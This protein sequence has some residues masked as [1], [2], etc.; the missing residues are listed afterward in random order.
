MKECK[1][2]KHSTINKRVLS[3]WRCKK[4]NIYVTVNAEWCKY[5]KESFS[6]KVKTMLNNIIK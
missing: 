5:Y 3:K 6:Y 2:C 4:L 1:N